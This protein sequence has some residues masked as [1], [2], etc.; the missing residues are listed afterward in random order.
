[1]RRISIFGGS[2]N[3]PHI[4]HKQVLE[5]LAAQPQFDEVWVVPV[6]QHAFGKKL[7]PFEKRLAM[8]RLLVDSVGSTKVKIN[9]AEKEINKQPNYTFDTIQHLHAKY[10]QDEF[11]IVVGS[12]VKAEL[13]KW[14]RIDEL[15]KIASFFF[16]PRNGY[17]KSDFAKVSSSEI[18]RKLLNGEPIEGLTIRSIIEYLQTHVQISELS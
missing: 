1:M 3:P 7:I 2:F 9:L 15:Q 10:P 12:D 17:E 16:L 13:D 14:H 11:S 5:H 18:R 6:Y 4:G 8:T